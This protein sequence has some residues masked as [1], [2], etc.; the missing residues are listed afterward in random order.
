VSNRIAAVAALLAFVV[1]LVVG[2]VQ[3]DNTFTTTVM[4]ALVAMLVTLV[5]G[6]VMGGM[7]QKMLEENLKSHEEKLRTPGESDR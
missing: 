7:A 2:G 1:C 4:R 3:A 5:I 6:L